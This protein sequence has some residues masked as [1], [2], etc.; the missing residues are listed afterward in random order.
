MNLDL[1][2]RRPFETGMGMGQE[3]REAFGVRGTAELLPLFE[4]AITLKSAGKP[5]ALQTLRAQPGD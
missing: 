3:F 1:R 2:F 5:D 4:C